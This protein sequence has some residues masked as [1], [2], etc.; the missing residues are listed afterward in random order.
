MQE[1]IRLIGSIR[2]HKCPDLLRSKK[3]YLDDYQEDFLTNI[4]Q[5]KEV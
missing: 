2:V 1:E 5:P 4:S 3:D